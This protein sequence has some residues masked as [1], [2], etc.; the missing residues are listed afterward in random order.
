MMIRKVCGWGFVLML[1]FWASLPLAAQSGLIQGVVV[2]P[3][4]AVMPDVKVTAWDEAKGILVRETVSGPD[5]SFQ[6]RQLLQGTYSIRV[7]ANGFKKFEA[8]GL[9]LDAAQAMNL[10]HV[11]MAV[12]ETTTSLTVE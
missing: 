2:D 6:L 7:E 5:G 3:V 12:G 11:R 1:V 4:D 8:R 9:V 10:G